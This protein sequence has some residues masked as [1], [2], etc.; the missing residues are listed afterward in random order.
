MLGAFAGKSRTANADMRT[1]RLGVIDVGSNSVRL[2]IHDVRGRAFQQ[3]FNEKVMAGLG[4]G[5][6]ASGRLHPEGVQMAVMAIRRF[7]AIAEAQGAHE[8]FAFATAAVR[9]AA[10]G[11][12][13][14][15]RVRKE[16]GI[17]LRILTGDE[18]ARLAAQ[19]VLANGLGVDGV[20]GDL[21]GSSLELATVLGGRYLGGGTYPLGPLALEGSGG[22]NADK[23]ADAVQASLRNAAELDAAPESFFAVGG[24]W[25]AVA[26]LH[27][28]L[29]KAPL[30]MLQH[31]EMDSRDLLILLGELTSGKRHVSR[32]RELARRRVDSIP[33]A[34]AVLR[35]VIQRGGFRS[36]VISSYGVRE[37][38]IF[39]SLSEK[40][41]TADPL[42]AGLDA[43]SEL[44]EAGAEFGRALAGWVAEA[45]AHTLPT[46]LAAAA[47]RLVDFGALLHPDH[48]ADLAFDL[49]ARAPLSGL[50]HK[51]RAALALAVASRHSRSVRNE[52]IDRLL[53][54]DTASRAR[55]LGAVMRLAVDL[56][57]RSATLLKHSRL[58]CDGRRLS[59]RL[60]P[61]WA[62]LM[63]ESVERRLQQAAEQMRMEAATSL[64]K[65]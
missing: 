44:D 26:S 19:G 13:F 62:H 48:R 58:D 61:A 24:A 47:C 43:I 21:G 64:E 37:G 15:Q 1:R 56:S 32:L 18:E 11:A 57:G 49:V 59:L 52:V 7:V 14:C 40:E 2:V 34:A 8:T 12:E 25:R 5:L 31:Y 6:R 10:D 53:D 17:P 45:A 50:S 22:F 9:E 63:S 27:M 28:E 54:E 42:M 3:R 4:R 35:G 30:R 60:S 65:A 51:E 55:A 29:S 16:S 36:V 20:I 38:I 46:R 23:V 41:R 33:Y 39:E